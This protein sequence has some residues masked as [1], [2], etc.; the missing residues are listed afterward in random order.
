M[1]LHLPPTLRKALLAVVIASAFNFAIPYTL[2]ED[3]N[4]INT[5]DDSNVLL[6]NVVIDNN[7]NLNANYEKIE[8]TDE[9]QVLSFSTSDVYYTHI[10]YVDFYNFNYI[11]I[12][13][14]SV[15]SLWM[16][17]SSSVDDKTITKTGEGVW[18]VNGTGDAS[19]IYVKDGT[20]Y[21]YAGELLAKSDLS[22]SAGATLGTS[23]YLNL[24]GD[25]YMEASSTLRLHH[26]EQSYVNFDSFSTSGLINLEI[27][28][29]TDG[30]LNKQIF[31]VGSG[32]V[33]V[34]SVD[35]DNNPLSIQLDNVSVVFSLT[36]S[37]LYVAD[38]SSLFSSINGENLDSNIYLV[39]D[40]SMIGS[41]IYITNNLESDERVLEWQGGSG[42][43]SDA[44]WITEVN[45]AEVTTSFAS[46]FSGATSVLF[47]SDADA[48]TIQVSMDGVVVRNFTISSQSDSE[49]AYIFDGGIITVE[50]QLN[51]AYAS[52]VY[53][54]GGADLGSSSVSIS[55]NTGT[56]YV[57]G[58]IDIASFYSVGTLQVNGN[59][60][61]NSSV[62]YGGLIVAD[63]LSVSGI[64]NEFEN[65]QVSG[66]VLSTGVLTVSGYLD[67]S[68]EMS[69]IGSLSGE[70]SLVLYDA[71]LTIGSSVVLDSYE[72]SWHADSLTVNGDI[73]I[74]SAVEFG[75]HLIADNAYFDS[76]AQMYFSDMTVAGL[77][78]YQGDLYVGISSAGGSVGDTTIGS[79]SGTGLFAP[80]Y[81][82]VTVTGLGESVVGR[83]DLG[84]GSWPLI[85]GVMIVEGSLTVTGKDASEIDTILAVGGD[86]TL[87]AGAY[88]PVNN[89]WYGDKRTIITINSM[90]SGILMPNTTST[91]T[92]GGQLNMSVSYLTVSNICLDYQLSKDVTP[93]IV[94]YIKDV[95]TLNFIISDDVLAGLGLSDQE[96]FALT[97]LVYACTANL[98]LN[99]DSNVYEANGQVYSLECL[100]TG[101]IILTATGDLPILTVWI[102][103]DGVWDTTTS[104]WLSGTLPSDASTIYFSGEGTTTVE[105]DGDKT[106]NIVNVSEE[107]Y[108]FTGDSLTTTK[109][110]VDAVTLTLENDVTV[111][112]A[113]SADDAS[114]VNSGNLSIGN[115]SN[116]MSLSGTGSLTVLTNASVDI[117]SFEQSAL[118]IQQGASL[119]LGSSDV[120]LDSLTNEGSLT[121]SGTVTLTAVTAVGGDITADTL[122]VQAGSVLGD[123]TLDSLIIDGDL[124]TKTS[125]LSLDSI[126]VLSSGDI[127]LDL[128]DFNASLGEGTY[129]IIDG[130]SLSWDS[131][132]LSDSMLQTIT[133]LEANY[134]ELTFTATADSLQIVVVSIIPDPEELTW[135]GDSGTEENPVV[136]DDSDSIWTGIPDDWEGSLTP[137]D[138][139]DLVFDLVEDTYIELDGDKTVED[140][141]LNNDG[142]SDSVSLTLTGDD[143]SA[144]SLTAE[145]VDLTVNN[146]TTVEGETSI[147]G[148][149]LTVGEDAS[150]ETGSLTLEDSNLSNEGTIIVDGAL[151]GDTV[152]NTGSLTV[153]DDTAVSSL[154]GGGDLALT[155]GSTVSI[156]SMEQDSLTLGEGAELNLGSDTTT[157]DTT[158]ITNLVNEGSIV[159][160][161]ALEVSEITTAG[162]DVTAPALDVQWGSTFSDLLVDSLTIEGSVVSSTVG[163]TV[164]S[165]ASMTTGELISLDV[166]GFSTSLTSGTYTI[167]DGVGDLTWADFDLSDAMDATIAALLADDRVAELSVVDGSLQITIWTGVP[168]YWDSSTDS[169]VMKN[170]GVTIDGSEQVLF[171][172]TATGEIVSYESF[173]KVTGVNIDADAVIDL[174]ISTA[175]VDGQSL[176]LANM[177]GDAD[178]TLSLIGSDA[179]THSV[180]FTNSSATV[181][182]NAISAQD[183]ALTVRNDGTN[184]FTLAAL[185]LSNV[186][187]TVESGA[188]FNL[189][190][191]S[192]VDSTTNSI[193]NEGSL[194]LSSGTASTVTLSGSGMTTIKANGTVGLGSLDNSAIT[195]EA[196][197]TLT[198]SSASSLASLAGTGTLDAS[199]IT[200]TLATDFVS[201]A[202]V[203]A[204]D[205]VVEADIELKALDVTDTASI[206]SGDSLT[207]ATLS[208][209]TATI[210]NAGTLTLGNASNI[211]TIT[212]S[213]T[214]VIAQNASVTINQFD[215]TSLSL[216]SGSTVS[217]N[218]DASLLE[219]NNLGTLVVANGTLTLGA[220]TTTYALAPVGSVG[221]TSSNYAGNIIAYDLVVNNDQ[222]ANDLTV[223]NSVTVNSGGSLT[224]DS[225]NSDNV[226]ATVTGQID[227]VGTGGVY[228]GSYVDAIINL[229]AADAQQTLVASADL[230]L[231]GSAGTYTLVAGTGAVALKSVNTS[232]VSYNLTSLG[233]SSIELMEASSISNANLDIVFDAAAF[234]STGT[235]Q[236]VFTGASLSMSNVGV[237]LTALN[238][239][240]LS[241][242][243]TLSQTDGV[244]ILNMGDNVTLTD[245]L[246]INLEGTLL[247]KYLTSAKFIGNELV[248]DINTAFYE[249]AIVSGNGAAG[250]SMIASVYDQIDPQRDTTGRYADLSSAMDSIDT[251]LIA[252][253]HDGVNRLSAAIAGTTTTAIGS[254]M[255]S[256][257]ERQLRSSNNRALAESQ[258]GY[259]GKG[260]SM[261]IAAEGNFDRLGND[262]TSG[263]HRF[264]SYGGSVGVDLCTGR[265]TFFGVSF[266]A[267]SGDLT[268]DSCD[269]GDGGLDTQFLSLYGRAVSGN[270]KHSYAMS[271]GWGSADLDRTVTHDNGYYKTTGDTDTQAFGVL[272]EL[273]YSV[274]KNWTLL[275]NSTLQNSHVNNYTESGSDAG[276][277]VGSQ[278]STWATFGVGV[279]AEAYLGETV[280]NRSCRLNTRAIVKFYAGDTGSDVDV[281]LLAGGVTSNVVG[282]DAGKVAVE[283]ATGLVIP[284]VDGGDVFVDASI[285]L[286]DEQSSVNVTAGYRFSF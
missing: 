212:G 253:N 247:S 8:A 79:L 56:L 17:F 120:S 164:D 225:L 269:Y 50:N 240:D 142:E 102:S 41:D 258:P 67:T 73:T 14:G 255:M 52:G 233:S 127:S 143:L 55:T 273:G 87:S 189:L 3:V 176:E 194:S 270:W 59:I 181:A 157:G 57:E 137:G 88:S 188:Q 24:S 60:E 224:V 161:N 281:S 149:D 168:R 210:T 68:S 89:D 126:G 239:A 111:T 174:S 34:L 232:G 129:T 1:K 276:L 93:L 256:E 260:G 69:N 141:T 156:E 274:N 83:I 54:N 95:A 101:N 182:N 166:T 116:I 219:L 98:T 11:D 74:H 43:W 284:V 37:G 266:T 242:L 2:A 169:S 251:M 167:I 22:V 28:G 65:L 283:F 90:S 109:M 62:S 154:T 244:V 243:K 265:G 12:A 208:A 221:S 236:V 223:L 48:G 71:D 160:D 132:E 114:I 91:L 158:T 86:L 184:S 278:S 237:T 92:L 226:S 153:G 227:V 277:N 282:T 84:A 147:T 72:C 108:T 18:Y 159:S 222:V 257:I 246:T 234:A 209:S 140:I 200:L 26:R 238:E 162:G 133:D 130:A 279:N 198:L 45:D 259:G 202:T 229:S 145:D 21:F 51:V 213:G 64:T 58:D 77:V 49:E 36:S 99:G 217:I 46:G 230:A 136:W 199:A 19:I 81:S 197:S 215:S 6:E 32:N 267:M 53:F 78:S 44:L 35:E 271:V 94:S 15:V 220:A 105:L 103:T 47:G 262:G 177:T 252:G 131:F 214:T 201:S 250:M 175:P 285:L 13:D 40:Y 261:W 146:N 249:D 27:E 123:L 9:N 80:G 254:A 179:A 190:S 61:L 150:L 205:L 85:G 124:S 113:L 268:S 187:L 76:D 128:L 216:E 122:T 139:T 172:D 148:A 38:A 193:V 155:D 275:V 196:G 206:S 110:D 5:Q 16:D 183:I 280:I 186:N 211:G 204:K 173:L 245:E 117:A 264:N 235:A 218:G 248:V 134:K 192:D 31:H 25:L 135:D 107:N 97:D 63:N 171:V 30:Y 7:Q 185:Q 33:T 195:L 263:G 104:D 4:N 152:D 165:L 23:S 121:T 180:V 39:I 228:L 66:D 82:N 118:T 75:G 100:T 272:Y 112:G 138:D 151:I 125:L 191:I 70:G 144:D 178:K 286:R 231:T 203:K 20:L 42:S 106:V 115:G 119:D 241:Q 29:Y 96:S 207:V 170:D 163:L 10:S